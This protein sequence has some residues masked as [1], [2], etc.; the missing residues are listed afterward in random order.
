MHCGV[1]LKANNYFPQQQ[2]IAACPRWLAIVGGFKEEQA[3]DEE[4]SKFIEKVVHFIHVTGDHNVVTEQDCDKD[5]FCIDPYQ[6]LFIEQSW[7]H[8]DFFVT[9]KRKIYSDIALVKTTKDIKYSYSV[10]PICLSVVMPKLQPPTN[11]TRLTVAGW[12]STATANYTDEKRIVDVVYL[13]D[14]K[15][16]IR[17]ELSHMCVGGEMGKDSCNGDSGGSLARRT[18]NGWVLEGIVLHIA[19]VVAK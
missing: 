11:G 17:Q 12:G 13:D 15:C 7:V 9:K 3:S 2:C 8:D 18:Q 1:F 19:Q 10:E 4:Y 14:D 6:R 5:G 16:R